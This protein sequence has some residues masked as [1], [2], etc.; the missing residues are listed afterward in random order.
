MKRLFFLYSCFAFA[1]LTAKKTAAQEK[2][3]GQCVSR[4]EVDTLFIKIKAG[5]VEPE[6]RRLNGVLRQENNQALGSHAFI[7]PVVAAPDYYQ[8][9]VY[10]ITNYVDLDPTSNGN[11]SS[12]TDYNC[13]TRSYDLAS[14]YDHDGIDI[15]LG[16]FGWKMMDNASAHVRAAE[17]GVIVERRD[18]EWDRTCT[19][20]VSNTT[21]GNYVA[22][23]HSDLSVAFYFHMKNGSVTDKQVGDIVRTGEYLGA[24]GSSGNSTGPHLHFEVRDE[25]GDL[26]DPFQNG[27][28]NNPTGVGSLWANEEPYYNKKILSVFTVDAPWV[29][30]SCDATG[31][32]NG[33]SEVVDFKNHFSTNGDSIYF[34]ATVRDAQLNNQVRLR[35]YKPDG[36]EIYDSTF[37]YGNTF[38][39][40]YT[41]PLQGMVLPADQGTYRLLCTYNGQSEPHFFTVGCPASQVLSGSRSSNTGV[42]SGGSVTSTET[43]SATTINTEYQA[44]TFIQLDPGFTANAGSEFSGRIN[45]CTVGSQLVKQEG[46]IK[47][48]NL[49]D[50]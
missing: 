19:F 24:V 42:I 29:S 17:G 18:G 30:A 2:F 34:T 50:R 5:R 6:R 15:G 14:G 32:S 16:P 45:N 27:A 26:L 7:W 21:G 39:T 48:K 10:V 31:V 28:C 47:L 43:F 35:M 38:T 20:G 23:E 36:S 8:P 25:D 49:N 12:I 33:I 4:Q 41:V 13:G 22:I 9:G 46:I 44:E 1:L 11:S 37:T 3:K 40:R